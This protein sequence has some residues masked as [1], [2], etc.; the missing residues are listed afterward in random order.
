MKLPPHPLPVTLD[1]SGMQEVLAQVVDLACRIMPSGS[2]LRLLARVDGTHAVVNFMDV[3]PS[4][5]E[6]RLGH[7]FN[8]AFTRKWRRPDEFHARSM[9]SIA[10]C[11]QIVGDHRGRIYAAPSPL[12]SLGVTLRLPLH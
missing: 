2:T 7:F 1:R 10:L 5:E 8:A 9:A 4:A 6:P 11:E 12:G 3:P